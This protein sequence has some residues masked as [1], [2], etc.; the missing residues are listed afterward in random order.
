MQAEPS[1]Q[2]VL[3]DL[4]TLD[5]A[6]AQLQ[7]RKRTLPVLKQLQELAKQR[8]VL[9]EEVVATDTRASDKKL[10]L[11]RVNE[12]LEPARARLARNDELVETNLPHKQL[13]AIISESEHLK[14]RIAELEEQHLAAE[15]EAEEASKKAEEVR[16]RR[17][18]IETEMKALIVERDE[19]GKQID[20]DYKANREERAQTAKLVAEPLLKLYNKIAERNIYGAAA[21]KNGKCGG[22][23]L[24]LD[25][26]DKK[27][28]QEASPQTVLRC[29]ECGRILVR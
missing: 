14:G 17:V 8:K 16:A 6:A 10:M 1:Q 23:G 29:E 25:E 13:Q 21:Y 2:S 12:D 11:D 22:C 9:L 18:K 24:A 5:T 26:T 27:R 19:Q 15:L 4:A 7:H 3:L 20:D 28:A